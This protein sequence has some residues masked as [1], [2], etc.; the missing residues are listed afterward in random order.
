MKLVG[1]SLSP[2][3]I[4]CTLSLCF[5]RESCGKRKS[6]FIISAIDCGLRVCAVPP[7][8]FNSIGG[9]E[10]GVAAVEDSETEFGGRAVEVGFARALIKL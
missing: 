9:D 8:T 5:A 3:T 6:N 1:P 7:H 4:L 2:A 10:R